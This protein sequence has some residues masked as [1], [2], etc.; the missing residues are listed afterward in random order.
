MPGDDVVISRGAVISYKR[1]RQDPYD[2]VRKERYGGRGYNRGQEAEQKHVKIIEDMRDK[3]V[4]MAA[5]DSD[6][7]LVCYVKNTVKY[8]IMDFGALFHAT[9]CKEELERFKLRSDKVRLADDKTLDIAQHHGLSSEITQ[10]PGGSSNTSEV[11]ENSGSFEDSRRSMKNTQ[12][13]DHP[14]T[15]EAPRL[16]RYEDPLESPGLQVKEE[17]D[18]R[19]RLVLSIV[20]FDDLHLEQLDVKTAFL[21]GDLDEDIYMTQPDGFRSAGKEE[22]LRAWYKR[23]DMDHCCYLKKVFEMKDRC[24]EKHVL[25]YVVTVG[26]TT[27]E[28]ESRLQKSITIFLDEEPCSDFHQVGDEREVEALRSFNWPPSEFITEDGVLLERGYSQFYA[29]SLGYL[30]SKVS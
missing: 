25:G 30:V 4:N 29:V 26:V 24:S 10:S 22:N 13:T 9:Y 27:V 16:H 3:V 8:R 15:R 20:A 28:W 17:R 19:K 18:G 11:F 23:C 2:G 7:A 5:G 14:P 12:K 1:Q 6:V 21:H